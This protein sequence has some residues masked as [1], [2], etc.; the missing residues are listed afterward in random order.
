MRI[1]FNGIVEMRTR[2][3]KPCGKARTELGFVSYRSYILPSGL[4]KTFRKGRVEE[5]SETDGAFL[6]QYHYTDSKGV[7]RNAFEVD[8]G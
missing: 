7:V 5:V 6:L 8:H 1:K 4:K 3:C 2:G